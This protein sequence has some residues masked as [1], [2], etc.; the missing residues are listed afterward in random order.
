MQIVGVIL[1]LAVLILAGFYFWYLSH[2]PAMAAQKVAGAQV[3]NIIV[4]SAYSPAV[5]EAELGQ[6]IRINF[7]RQESTS[8]SEFVSFPD[9]KIRRELLENQTVAIELNPTKAGEFRFV[10]DMG[11]YQGKLIVK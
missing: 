7:T 9:F 11:M 2:Q 4:K 1:I 6:P 3:F 10:C 8:C 5:I